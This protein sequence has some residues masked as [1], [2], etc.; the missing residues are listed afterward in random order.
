MDRATKQAI[1][2]HEKAI[3]RAQAARRNAPSHEASIDLLEQIRSHQREIN[4][5]LDR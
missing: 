1:R 3:K 4:R 2:D 5:L